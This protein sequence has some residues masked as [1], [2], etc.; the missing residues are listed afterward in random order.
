MMF[1]PG[2]SV[3]ALPGG[4][5]SSEGKSV[6]TSGWDQFLTVFISRTKASGLT[7]GVMTENAPEFCL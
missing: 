4:Q 2:P 7:L 5:L 1:S 6:Q 3:R